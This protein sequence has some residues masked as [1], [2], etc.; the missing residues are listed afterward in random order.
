MHKESEM[1]QIKSMPRLHLV[2]WWVLSGLV[3]LLGMMAMIESWAATFLLVALAL[4]I[5]P[6]LYDKLSRD[7]AWAQSNS[8]R[9]LI[10]WGFLVA[11]PFVANEQVDARNTQK[12]RETAQ[13]ASAKAADQARQQAEQAAQ[14]RKNLTAEF[15]SNRT[16][17]IASLDDALEKNDLAG[18]QQ[19]YSKY[20]EVGDT[21]LMAY[22]P[23]IDVLKVQTAHDNELKSAKAKLNGLKANDYAGA[24]AVY[25]D[26]VR[27]DPS[28]KTY[29]DALSKN[30]AVQRV[31]DQKAQKALQDAEAAAA[32]TKLVEAQFS[33][34]DGSHRGMERMIK[35]SMNDPGSYEHIETRYRDMGTKIRVTEKFRGRNG[36]GGM[37]VNTVTADFDLNGGL[38]AV[39]SQN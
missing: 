5:C 3:I 23:K 39:I 4:I 33:G 35:A 13:I 2:G 26:L 30:Q 12:E 24:I 32:R 15:N 16:T 8:S 36:F 29:V 20:S 21:Q 7:Q 14:R 9:I 11:A 27:L 25:T 28:N 6:P 17:T 19:I 18:A 1:T 22:G 38:L 34:W 10:V 37:V 31:A